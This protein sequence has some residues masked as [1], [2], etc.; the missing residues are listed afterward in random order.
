MHCTL[1][2]HERTTRRMMPK[3]SKESAE[4]KNAR[5]N[6]ERPSILPIQ[7]N[8]TTAAIKTKLMGT[9]EKPVVR[10]PQEIATQRIYEN[11][12]KEMRSIMNEHSNSLIHTYGRST[13]THTHSRMHAYGSLTSSRTTAIHPKTEV[14]EAQLIRFVHCCA[15]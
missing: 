7:V 14:S 15:A 3:R 1:R 11:N 12:K 2:T 9:E 6:E 13:H 8:N 4:N 10:S 5:L